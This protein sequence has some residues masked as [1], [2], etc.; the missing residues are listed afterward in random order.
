MTC[1]VG[2]EHEGK[3]YLGGDSAAADT[4]FEIQDRL[5]E[6]VFVNGDFVMG[7]TTSFRMGQILRYAFTPPEHMPS[8]DDM[9]YMVVDFID[10]IRSSFKEKGYIGREEGTTAES[11]GTFLVGYKN[12]L[13]Y[14][15]DDF[16]VARL[17]DGFS[18]VGCGAKIA[19]GSLY[20]TQD[21]IDPIA[22]LELAL[23]AAAHFS[24]GVR[25]PFKFVVTGQSEYTSLK[26]TAKPKHAKFSRK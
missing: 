15:E 25:A 6:K 5:D 24:A 12:S 17:G 2:I 16:Q 26:P 22:R 19:L 13:Y 1:I 11:G 8:K 4:N 20:S 23:K 10:G 9:S 18:A 21:M 7:F 3:V 14:I